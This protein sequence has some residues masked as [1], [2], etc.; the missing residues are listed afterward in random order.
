MR[1]WTPIFIMGLITL[2][3]L[4]W[5]LFGALLAMT[6]FFFFLPPP[7]WRLIVSRLWNASKVRY[8]PMHFQQNSMPPC[9]DHVGQGRRQHV[10]Q[11]LSAQTLG[12]LQNQWEFFLVKSFL[13]WCKLGAPRWFPL[14]HRNWRQ[15]LRAQ[16]LL[17]PPDS[18]ATWL[19]CSA[20]LAFFSFKHWFKVSG[21][22]GQTT[23]LAYFQTQLFLY[24]LWRIIPGGGSRIRR[25]SWLPDHI[26][27][28]SKR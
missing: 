7:P 2:A 17:T 22:A 16:L 8:F 4:M 20:L 12:S 6:D 25:H 3:K 5:A 11:P 27:L 23:V 10:S 15:Q 28:L 26:R 18:T 19:P 1:K 13:P 9:K 14:G 24:G 21:Q